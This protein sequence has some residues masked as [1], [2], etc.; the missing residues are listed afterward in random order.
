MPGRVI[1]VGSLHYDIMVKAPD[2]PRKGET[3]MGESWWPKCGGKGGNQSVEAALA[4][5][6]VSM[7]GAVGDDEFGRV[8]LANLAAAGVDA[9]R[10]DVV[11]DAGSGMSVA[12]QDSAGDYGAVVVSG[13]NRRIEIAEDD[14]R[15]WPAGGWLVLQNEVP[16]SVN[17]A[18]ARFARARGLKI[19]L[20]AA[21]AIALDPALDALVDVL[22]VNAIEAE[23]LGGGAV[24]DLGTAAV[25]ARR[26]SRGNRTVVVTAGGDGVAF[27]SPDGDGAVA[28]EPVR[29]VS[30][31]GAGDCFV[32]T[33]AAELAAG[34]SFAAAVV[35]ANS[36]AGRLV[37][38]SEEERVARLPTS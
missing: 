31:H 9:R 1:V 37:S 35:Q 8:L 10:V 20:N 5:A 30:T 23:M 25:A 34:S 2:R 16:P 32:G 6:A 28:A 27:S 21:P 19:L 15:D 18:A 33:L 3:V 12:I 29:L 26:L 24:E 14:T 36:A 17:L 38:L 7:I 4:G 13:A 11:A 22:V